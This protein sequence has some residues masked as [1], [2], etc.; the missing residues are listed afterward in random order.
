MKHTLCWLKMSRKDSSW[1]MD[2]SHCLL[3]VLLS[4]L[5]MQS[6]KQL[7]LCW[8]LKFHIKLYVIGKGKNWTFRKKIFGLRKL[9]IFSK[10]YIYIYI[11]M[12][13]TYF[14]I[15]ILKLFSECNFARKVVYFVYYIRNIFFSSISKQNNPNIGRNIERVAIFF[16][17]ILWRCQ[18]MQKR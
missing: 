8:Y 16:K 13:K 11:Y 7:Y 14:C 5:T 18:I 9:I 3:Q 10:I 1:I 2:L 15:I 6:L 17:F 4:K 12:N